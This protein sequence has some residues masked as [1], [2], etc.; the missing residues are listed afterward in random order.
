[1]LIHC[2]GSYAREGEGV[3]SDCGGRRD[4]GDDDEREDRRS[5]VVVVY[6]PSLLS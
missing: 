4:D 5:F 1:M 2:L 3:E 6:T